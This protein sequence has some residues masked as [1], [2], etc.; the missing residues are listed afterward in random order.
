MSLDP[1]HSELTMEYNS[2]H[3]NIVRALLTNDAQADE[4]KCAMPNNQAQ[5]MFLV[6]VNGEPS[7]DD[8]CSAYDKA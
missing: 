6:S 3:G 1:K 2:F 5:H 8:H 7:S 4:D